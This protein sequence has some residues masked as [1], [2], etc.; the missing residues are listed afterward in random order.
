MAEKRSGYAAKH[1]GPEKWQL[2]SEK[3]HH[4]FALLDRWREWKYNK[5]QEG[6]EV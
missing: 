1:K 6:V 4:A 3:R 2:M 5:N